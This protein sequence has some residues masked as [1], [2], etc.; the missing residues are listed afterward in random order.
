MEK[1]AWN[2][3]KYVSYHVNY[4]I[5]FDNLM[6]YGYQGLDQGVN[7]H[8]LIS[9]IRYDKFF[10]V[11][12]TVRA[13]RDKYERDFDAVIDYFFAIHLTAMTNAEHQSWFI[14]QAKLDEW[15]TTS[16]AHSTFKGNMELRNT[17]KK[18]MTQFDGT[19][20]AVI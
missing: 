11:V 13:P 9:G 12:V 16:S 20:T 3:E 14:I 7:T 4:H 5:I 18:S 17:P 2:W 6:E 19:A 1:K 10:S 15:Q 8:N